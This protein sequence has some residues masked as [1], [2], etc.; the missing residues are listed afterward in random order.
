MSYPD[1]GCAP[2]EEETAYSDYNIMQLTLPLNGRNG[3]FS[4][5]ATISDAEY[6]L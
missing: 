1:F 5:L 6:M 2:S 4:P 3:S